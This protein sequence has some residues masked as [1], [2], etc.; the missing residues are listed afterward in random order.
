MMRWLVGSSMRFRGLVVAIAAGAIVLGITQLPGTPVDTLPEF[1]RTVVEVQT[2]ALG[3]SA[4][5]VEQ[6]IT[7]PL[8]QDLLNGVAFLEEIESASLPGLSSVVMT[9]EPG[10]DLLDARQV[11]AER[12]TQAVAAAG[13]PEVAKPPQMLQPLSSTSRVAMVRLTPEE[14]SPIEVSVLA[15]WVIVPRLLGVPGVA[16][17]A[18]WGFRDRQL[19]VL[20]DPARLHEAGVTLGQ[21]VR[22]AGNALEVSP[23]SF[24]E[25]SSPGTGGW[26][27]T[28]NQRLNI[29]HQQ[30]IDSPEELAAVPLED[31]DGRAVIV[32]GRP[33][34]LGDVTDVVEDH[35]PLIGDAL[36]RDGGCL[37]LVVEKFPGANTPE[38]TRGI[39][40]AIDAMRPGLDGMAIDNGIYR[41]ADYIEASFRNLG[42]SLAV[43]GILLVL[44]LGLLLF[45][46]R[47]TL[48]A[49]AGVLVSLA[50]AGL[51]LRWTGQTVNAM[52]VA[53]LAAAL[54]LITYD[55]V[56]DA[57]RIVEGQRRREEEGA[58]AP[59]WRALLDATVDTRRTALTAFLVVAVTLVPVFSME[60]EAG[61]FLPPI[62]VALL[63]AMAVA[64]VV[65]LTVIPA[66][67]MLLGSDGPGRGGPV[68]PRLERWSERWTARAV[69]R[70]AGAIA[71]LGAAVLLGLASL[72]FLDVS[73]RPSLREHDVLVH[74]EAPPGTSLPRMDA[75]VRGVLDELAA[76]PGV[77][78]VGAH[79][80]RAVTSD[81]IVNVNSGEIWLGIEPSADHGAT[82]AAIRDVVDRHPEA[83]A[84][85]G[86]YSATRVAELLGAPG[87][88]LTVRVY[89]ED[90]STLQDLAEEV[91][92]AVAG[93]EGVRG[94]RVVDQ[95]E[96]PVIEVQVDVRRA[97]A[98][99][100]KPGDARRAAAI[101]LSG[102]TVGNLFEEQKVFDVVVWG[103]PG[104]RRDEADV[105]DLLIDT[106]DGGQ[107]PLGRIADVR[108]VPNP[109]VIRH[110]SVMTY[111]D[112]AVDV[113]GRDPAAV[114]GD[115][116]R[117]LGGV[118]FPL[119]YHAEVLGNAVERAAARTRTL[120]VASAAAIGLFLLR[121]AALASWRLAFLAF[122][123]LPMSLA[124]VAVAA[125]VGGG[126][127]TLGVVAAGVA[128]LGLA[129]RGT[130]V[131]IRRWQ[132]LERAGTPFGPE[133]VARGW[134]E[135]GR[136][137]IV[138][139][140]P[141][142]AVLL[143]FALGADRPGLE[144]VGPL[145]R[146]AL[147]GLVTATVLHVVVLPPLYLR[148][149]FVRTPDTTA[150]DLVVTVPDVEP[151]PRA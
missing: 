134:R 104:I 119:E 24:L 113:A 47:A 138:A 68:I 127:V 50:G 8:E 103:A 71:V 97:Q 151:A 76:L 26:I 25:A 29:F 6:F 107:V 44:V 147:G 110:E 19:Q 35:Q 54:G 11:V 139:A 136:R 149:G 60:R 42:R 32:R 125:V 2:E 91:R 62:A 53:G 59:R 15:R 7:V 128:I 41:P 86:T 21:V 102:I 82:L 30:A 98:H 132:A 49:A 94:S 1:K 51:V 140:L 121:Q 122:V 145:A 77:R 12:L 137:L 131:L 14:L 3:L 89:G 75:I 39:E 69:G 70:P 58:G 100:V 120:L 10:T 143:P 20:V 79:V 13:L 85:V 111:L 31:E 126:T 88:D 135:E 108:V 46:W 118:D 23:L 92:G 55:A 36:C 18:I 17:V 34:L 65:A 106:P 40:E 101:L 87:D 150:E 56:L 129:T 9:F 43:A 117:A 105:R 5:E 114:A 27:D 109:T 123:L 33:V 22:T 83:S 124:G 64:A 96:E 28:V 99:G 63:L 144:V 95:P 16:N 130:L 37:L 80:G 38:V 67:G 93:V 78:D 74:L 72:P 116:D 148:F 81:Q 133:L 52:V 84:Q 45:E 141:A 73:M 4:E 115:V 66:L 48:I 142:A 61:A 90:E 146:A 57:Q 112:V